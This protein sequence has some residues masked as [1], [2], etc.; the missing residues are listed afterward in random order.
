MIGMSQH[1]AATR[2]ETGSADRQSAAMAR[3]DGGVGGA[4]TMSACVQGWRAPRRVA[5]R[6]VA[7]RAGWRLVLLVGC[8]AMLLSQSQPAAQRRVFTARLTPVPVDTVTVRTIVGLGA[9]TAVL[10]GTTLTVTGKF[11]MNSAATIAHLHRAP[12]GLRGPNVF[13][14][15][16]T[17]ADSGTVEGTLKLTATQVEDLEKG[18]YYLQIHSQQQP[19]GQLRGWLLK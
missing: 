15:T 10:D 16:V 18:W 4:V 17:K 6:V 5:R 1:A 2:D 14:L 11:E 12:R 3:P 7:L 13:D 19:D 8:A 9:A